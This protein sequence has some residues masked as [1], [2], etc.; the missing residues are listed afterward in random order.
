MQIFVKDND[1]EHALKVLKRKIARDGLLKQLKTK[2]AYEKPSEKRK[3]KERES[4]RRIRKAM[5]RRNRR[6]GRY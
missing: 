2:R 6:S 3:R 4:L 5:A 1:V